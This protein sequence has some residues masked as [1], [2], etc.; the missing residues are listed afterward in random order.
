LKRCG[1]HDARRLILA[2][3]THRD[4]LSLVRELLAARRYWRTL[5]LHI[6]LAVLYTSRTVGDASLHGGLTQT[7]R[8]FDRPESD[9]GSGVFLIDGT[10]LSESELAMLDGSVSAV[11]DGE[12]GDL[13]RHLDWFHAPAT[14][15]VKIRRSRATAY[16][17]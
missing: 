11:F 12:R 8:S 16:Q 2:R 14:G 9:G 7:V 10:Q 6:D 3:A 4:H 15:G 5:G 13:A 1:I 17:G